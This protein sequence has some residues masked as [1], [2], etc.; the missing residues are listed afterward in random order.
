MQ[1]MQGSYALIQFSPVPER[2]EFL[3]IGVALAIP[4]I[5]FLRVRFASSHGRIDRYFRSSNPSFLEQ[6]KEGLARRLQR[7]FESGF[8]V[9]ALEAFASKRA[10]ELRM[11]PFRPVAV[12]EPEALLE[13]LFVE[14]VGEDQV[15]RQKPRMARVLKEAF[16][17]AS[18]YGL[19]E[20]RPEPVELP[21]LGVSIKAPF[22]YQNGAYNLIDGIQFGEDPSDALE[23]A[24]KMALEGAQLWKQ[25]NAEGAPKRL[26]IVADFKNRPGAFYEVVGEQLDR[27]HVRLYRLDNLDPLVDDISNN[28]SLHSV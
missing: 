17:K 13:R 1:R 20:E 7:E 18:V 25:S 9:A 26:V 27:S 15:R 21:E 24:G 5:Q 6:A 12:D 8:Q 22:G 4:E 10:N 2:M 16:V 23:K 28:A 11:A 3:N 19:V 14:L